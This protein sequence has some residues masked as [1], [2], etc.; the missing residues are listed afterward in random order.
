MEEI[1]VYGPFITRK[2]AKSQSPVLK[3]YFINK[4]CPRGHID[5]RYVTT[6][7][8]IKCVYED[9]YKY[10]KNKAKEKKEEICAMEI[11]CQMC[12]N[13]FNPEWG[14]GKKSDA[15]KYCNDECRK[16]AGNLWSRNY[17]N[18]NPERRKLAAN[19]YARRITKE[20]GDVW[21]RGRDRHDKY[22]TER[23][24]TDPKFALEAKLRMRH[25]QAIKGQLKTK[26]RL[27][28]NTECKEISLE[29]TGKKLKFSSMF[30]YWGCT[31]EELI[32][33]IES[34]WEEGMSWN[35]WTPNG[36]H[37]DH[38][39]PMSSFNMLDENQA[40]KCWH[41]SNLRPLWANENL[42]KSNKRE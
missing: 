28:T 31:S 9:M 42:K 23:L 35:N 29:I 13:L 5:M 20:K 39:I 10:Q 7:R 19:K 8:C 22:I 21:K 2:Q 25:I 27:P 14:K 11:E 36:W 17:V 24:K 32:Q 18:R 26:D 37:I 12:G 6:G 38:I 30:K 40:K 41:Y 4:V 3:H 16:K 15:A 33:H 34:Q 1:K